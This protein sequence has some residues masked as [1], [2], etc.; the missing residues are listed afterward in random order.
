MKR[1]RQA[2]TA[3]FAATFLLLLACTH[4]DA[5]DGPDA[6]TQ[7]DAGKTYEQY[8]FV[9]S[10]SD[11][12]A[13][14]FETLTE[15]ARI[16][17]GAGAGEVHAT[18][19]GS[20]VW[21]LS[22]DENKVTIIDVPSLSVRHRVDVGVRPVHSFLDPTEEV[23]WVGNDGSGEVSRIDLETGD[24]Q[25]ILT[26]NGH[27]KMALAVGE[28]GALR[29]VYVSN[30]ADSTIS[31]VN[32]DGEVVAN[33]S[34]GPA[35]HGMDYSPLTKKVY[36]CSGDENGSIEVISTDGD[37]PHSVVSRIPLPERCGYLHVTADGRYAHATIRG[38]DLL[39]AVDLENETVTTFAAGDYP[40]KFQLKGEVAYVSNVLTP[41]VTRVDLSNATAAHTIGVGAAKVADGRGHRGLRLFENRLFVPNAADETVSVIDVTT[42]DVVATLT[43]IPHPTGIAMAGVRGGTPYPR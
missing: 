33:I 22:A 15:A 38:L 1:V 7:A 32:P 19:D 31:A 27:H 11:V 29:F 20:T 43:G 2:S 24:E 14:D 25:R 3:A 12:I 6:N 9:A 34:V 5:D 18:R 13:L 42:D 40:D 28:D 17:V 21:V 41:T 23:I 4:E 35:P 8:V 39:A 36:N 10:G 26:G 16:E 30:I 37:T